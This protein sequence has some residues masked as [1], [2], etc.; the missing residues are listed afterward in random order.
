MRLL[1]QIRHQ[2]PDERHDATEP[3][4]IF[5]ELGGERL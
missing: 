5:L 3:L 2:R 4:V 1:G